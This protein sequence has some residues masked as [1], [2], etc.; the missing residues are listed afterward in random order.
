VLGGAR[1][2]LAAIARLGH[3]RHRPL[4]AVP[5]LAGPR[6]SDSLGDVRIRATIH[7][8]DAKSF[9]SAHGLPVTREML[10]SDLDAAL[11]AATEIGWP[12]A[13]K[14][15]SDQIAHKSEH[16][17]VALAIGSDAA[18]RDAYERLMRAA[19]K[20]VPPPSVAGVLV[21]EMVSGG[22]ETFVGVN[23]D[24][25]F[26]PV[27]VA[28]VGGVGIEIFRD[29]ALRL[30]PLAVGDAAAMISELRAYPLLQGARSARPYD[31]PALIALIEAIGAIAWAERDS[32]REIDLN[33]VKLFH[34]GDGCRIVDALIVPR[35]T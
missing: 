8:A 18:L 15:V 34:S 35:A 26:G 3:A 28:G 30:L 14:I 20:I 25:D 6:L 9:F 12:V 19:A 27:I 1:Q 22:I 31:I 29:Y 17:L 23:R 2:G 24:P 16:G 32:V 13:I 21:Q 10:A 33:P 5:A 11:R 7:E 4:Q